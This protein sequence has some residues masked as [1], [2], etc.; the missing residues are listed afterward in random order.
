MS[1]NQPNIRVSLVGHCGPDSFA[2]RS[3]V[4]GFIPGVKIEKLDSQKEFEAQVGEFDLHLVNRVLDGAFPNE[5]G[6]ELI[7][8]HHAGNPPM[9]LISNFPEALQTA[10]EAGGVMG[11]GKRAMRSDEARQALQAALGIGTNN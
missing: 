8:E 11:F 10:V 1:T 2:L 6:I 7:R 4:A 5:S 9:M 3:A